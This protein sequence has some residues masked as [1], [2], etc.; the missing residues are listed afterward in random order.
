MQ[1]NAEIEEVKRRID[2]ALEALQAGRDVLVVMNGKPLG[3][4]TALGPDG[5]PEPADER[6]EIHD[7][8][9][10]LLDDIEKYLQRTSAH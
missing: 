6:V 9:G 7:P 2:R 3:I 4:V 5:E 10:R 1:F 8:S